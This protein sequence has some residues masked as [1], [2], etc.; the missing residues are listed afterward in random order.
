MGG[1]ARQS[2]FCGLKHDSGEDS[3]FTLDLHHPTCNFPA[4]QSKM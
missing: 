3:A 2:T 4:I 1:A